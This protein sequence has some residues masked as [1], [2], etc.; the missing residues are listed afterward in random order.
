MK[1]HIDFYYYIFINDIRYL[2][3]WSIWTAAARR[4]SKVLAHIVREKLQMFCIWWAHRVRMRL[5]E[6]TLVSNKM[7]TSIS[8]S[9]MNEYAII[10]RKYKI[11]IRQRTHTHHAF[12]S[13]R[14]RQE[15]NNHRKK[16]QR[17]A[18]LSSRPLITLKI[19]W[20]TPAN[21]ARER[22]RE[23]NKTQKELF[24][25]NKYFFFPFCS[26]LWSSTQHYK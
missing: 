16:Q 20:K 4:Y 24:A 13:S 22:R 11:M 23:R 10:H 9:T 14:F 18:W 12:R 15:N 8:S 26:K 21:V 5:V 7:K 17:W 6:F 19:Q 2:V 25:L 1:S 3:S